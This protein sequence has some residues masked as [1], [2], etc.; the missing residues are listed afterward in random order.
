VEV[1]TM[2]ELTLHSAAVI[3]QVRDLKRIRVITRHGRLAGF[4]EPLPD[5]TTGVLFAWALTNGVLALPSAQAPGLTSDEM[6]PSVDDVPTS[7]QR[8]VLP[9]KVGVATSRELS[10]HTR[11][12]MDRVGN[13]EHL[14]VTRHGRP[15]VALHP[16]SEGILASLLSEVP[17]FVGTE[18]SGRR[19]GIAYGVPTSMVAALT[20]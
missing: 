1:V 16:F 9:E 2:R 12:V 3:D 17:E 6:R 7:E 18:D 8:A 4:I 10:Q 5:E 14:V 20:D 11:E 15:V 13:G 19:D